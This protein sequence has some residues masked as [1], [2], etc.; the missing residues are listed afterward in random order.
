MPPNAL[1][2]APAPLEQRQLKH[3]W[4]SRKSHRRHAVDNEA[5]AH[6]LHNRLIHV[7][8]AEGS[9]YKLSA[10]FGLEPAP[11]SLNMR[12]SPK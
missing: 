12:S 8:Q 5:Y 6:R 11:T 2:P 7:E 1:Q 3:S 10:A 9:N 4:S